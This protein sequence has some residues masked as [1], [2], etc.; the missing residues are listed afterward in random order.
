MPH[1]NEEFRDFMR[2]FKRGRGLLHRELLEPSEHRSFAYPGGPWLR[3][4]LDEA[5]YAKTRPPVT[6]PHA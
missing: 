2:T 1:P 6:R 4:P 3:W 5:Q